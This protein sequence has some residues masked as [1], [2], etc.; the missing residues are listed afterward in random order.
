[1]SIDDQLKQ[2]GFSRMAAMGALEEQF[3]NVFQTL[4]PINGLSTRQQEQLLAQAEVLN[5][6]T[7]KFVFREG[8]RD[9]FSYFLLRGSLE[10]LS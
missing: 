9:D 2:E 4:V 8:D 1:L 7:R 6:G 5:F 3:E 10:L